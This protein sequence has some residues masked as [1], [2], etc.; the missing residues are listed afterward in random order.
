MDAENDTATSE[1]LRPKIMKNKK[2]SKSS[3]SIENENASFSRSNDIDFCFRKFHFS[4]KNVQQ[5]G[6]LILHKSCHEYAAREK[7]VLK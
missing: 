5:T 7:H 1:F 2:K 4:D 3:K 6:K